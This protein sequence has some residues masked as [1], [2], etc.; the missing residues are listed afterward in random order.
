MLERMISELTESG[1]PARSGF[2]SRLDKM[3]STRSFGRMKPPGPV[4]AADEDVARS[5]RPGLPRQVARLDRLAEPD[6]GFG[7]Q[8]F[9]GRKL[10]DR[11][12][13]GLLLL[14]CVAHQIG[15]DAA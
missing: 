1:P 2:L 12:D 3:T 7:H 10:H 11:C 9:G 5:F 8:H 6:V 4:A 15:R 14:V 13:G